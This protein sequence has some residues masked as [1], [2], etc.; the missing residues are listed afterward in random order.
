MVEVYVGPLHAA[1]FRQP[2]QRPIRP[3]RYR[4]GHRAL[5]ALRVLR[6]LQR[7]TLDVE[8]GAFQQQLIN[9]LDLPLEPMADSLTL[10]SLQYAVFLAL[11]F[12][13]ELIAGISGFIFRHEVRVE[14]KNKKNTPQQRCCL[15]NKLHSCVSVCVQI[16]GTFFTTYNEAVMRYDGLDDRS[17]AVDDVQRSVS[18]GHFLVFKKMMSLKSPCPKYSLNN[19]K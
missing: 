2:L 7:S 15:G 8:T 19:P 12:M 9:I 6:H 17:L 4:S 10:Y 13:T 18:V 16:N 11:V 5:R 3:H 1:D 14:K